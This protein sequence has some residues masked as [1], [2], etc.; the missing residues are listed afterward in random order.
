M[1]KNKLALYIAA[2]AFG[3]TVGLICLR[4]H[5]RPNRLSPGENLWRLSYFI[6]FSPLRRGQKYSIA[7]PYE[8]NSVR[9]LGKSLYHSDF[10]ADTVRNKEAGQRELICIG[11]KDRDRSA[12]SCQFD[13]LTTPY[14]KA[15]K[16]PQKSLSADKRNKYLII[17]RKLKKLCQDELA[18]LTSEDIE[19]SRL[20][21]FVFTYCRENLKDKSGSAYDTP[22][23]VLVSGRATPI[24][25][26]HTFIALCRASSVPARFVTGFLL[27]ASSEVTPI[28]WAEIRQGGKWIPFDPIRGHSRTIPSTFVPIGR[29]N[30][31]ILTTLEGTDPKIKYSIERLR[32]IQGASFSERSS[33]F[34][35]LDLTLLP[36]GMQEV[37]ALMLLLPIGAF[38]TALFRNMVGLQTFGTFT[39]SL[40]GLS[41]VYADWQTGLLVLVVVLFIG[42]FS[43]RILEHLQLTMVPRLGIV[44]TLSVLT[45]AHLVALFHN[46]GA[47]PS[48]RVVLLPVVI[49]TM[50]IERFFVCMEEDSFSTALKRVRNTL[51]VAFFC[52][53]FLS[54]KSLGRLLVA[55]PEILILVVGL[56]ILVG[57]YVGYRLSE[58]FRFK[59]I[60]SESGQ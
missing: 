26:V 13:L 18:K 2:A 4:K 32:A 57:R 33:W 23:R 55:Y 35:L 36:H 58:L 22:Q 39:P 24:G 14:R 37:L 38:I 53:L 40:I 34:D 50:L 15:K 28:Y 25:R 3:L 45:M 46:I 9:V 27:L 41:F 6:E 29:G 17:D 30:N 54:S 56:M 49:L 10:V 42:V 31:P 1:K 11:R 48:A 21:D 7:L 47:T 51:A 19:R 5:L 44:M 12:I 20:P 60:V 16:Q 8:T 43:R 59:D 52:W